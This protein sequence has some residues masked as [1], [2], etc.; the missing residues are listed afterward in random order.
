M[1]LPALVSF[2]V[3]RTKAECNGM[4]KGVGRALACQY[5]YLRHAL[6]KPCT[7]PDPRGCLCVSFTRFNL[8]SLPPRLQEGIYLFALKRMGLPNRNG[9]MDEACF[10]WWYVHC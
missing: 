5:F 8:V 2:Y 4:G 9:W 7:P 3:L 10:I 6:G 1:Q